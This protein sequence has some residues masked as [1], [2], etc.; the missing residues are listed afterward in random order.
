MIKKKY[1]LEIKLKAVLAFQEGAHYHTIQQR[2]GIKNFSQIYRWVKW[3]QTKQ[4]DRLQPK[5]GPQYTNPK[6]IPDQPKEKTYLLIKQEI[7]K[8]LKLKAPLNKKVF[9]TIIKKYQQIVPLKQLRKWLGLTKT[10]YYR[11]L[12]AATSSSSPLTIQIQQICLQNKYYNSLG[13]SRFI[14]VYR[15]V[16]AFL[17]S[18]G[19]KVNAKTVYNKMKALKSLC[20]TK[21]NRYIKTIHQQAYYRRPL[22]TTNLLKNNFTASQP[23]QKLC[24]DFTCFIYGQH[25]RLYLSII[26]DLYNREIVAYQW[27][28]QQ[29]NSLVLKTL[30]QLPYC[31]QPGIFHSDQGSQYTSLEF[32]TVLTSKNLMPSFSEKGEP[33]QNACVE[34]FFSNLKCETFYLEKKKF[35][36]KNRLINL[37][38][39]FIQHYNQSRQLSFLNYVSPLQYKQ[40]KQQALNR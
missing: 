12:K 40:I 36:T 5:R 21:K 13:Q 32:Q 4:W 38:D 19:V 14:W 9:L 24:A 20:Q 11:W 34:A 23:A 37:I 35:C 30:Q 25:Q 26:M 8:I 7:Q 22:S 1:S 10:T 27:A 33:S 3:F 16:H 17:V 15:K 2:L 29:T 31:T 28:E 39:T 18:Q 6:N